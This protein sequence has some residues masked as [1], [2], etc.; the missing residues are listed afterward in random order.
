MFD[1]RRMKTVIAELRENADEHNI[2]ELYR[3]ISLANRLY[4]K[5]IRGIEDSF[6][7]VLNFGETIEREAYII[8]DLLQEYLDSHSTICFFENGV[9]S[10]DSELNRLIE[11]SI[12]HF[13]NGNKEVAVEQLW[14]AFERA[15]TVLN[16]S[17][18]KASA[19]ELINTI[20]NGEGCYI[21][22]YKNEFKAL[23]DIGNHFSIRHH[24]TNRYIIDSEERYNFFFFRCAAL[25]TVILNYLK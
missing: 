11:L 14:S 7:T 12:E 22:M 18:K 9:N 13:N 20:S 5:E 16:P 6:E 15:K 24:E 10:R 19:E 17:D 21:E 2:E 1:K 23:T 3:C 25:M 8:A 4:G